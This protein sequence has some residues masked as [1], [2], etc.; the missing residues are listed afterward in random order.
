[1]ERKSM[2]LKI[3][4]RSAKVSQTVRLI[5]LSGHNSR[6]I[7]LDWGH[8]GWDRHSSFR[9]EQ[10]RTVSSKWDILLPIAPGPFRCFLWPVLRRTLEGTL[11]NAWASAY[12]TEDTVQ[13]AKFAKKV[14]CFMVHYRH[15]LYL[16]ITFLF[17]L[18]PN[19]NMGICANFEEYWNGNKSTI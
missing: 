6:L 5:R 16:H 3:A 2:K 4:Q 7:C 8:S 17:S 11:S 19:K 1:M 10:K 18:L 14:L 13:K 12:S 9:C 15:Q